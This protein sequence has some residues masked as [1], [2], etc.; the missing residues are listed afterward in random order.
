MSGFYY[1]MKRFSVG[2]SMMGAN[3]IKPISEHHMMSPL[4]LEPAR[5]LLLHLM[6]SVDQTQWIPTHI[7]Y[8][9]T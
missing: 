3:Y 5:I 2:K 4:I 8:E 6:L 1:I 9:S 7:K